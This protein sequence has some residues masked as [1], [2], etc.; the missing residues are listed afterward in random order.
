MIRIKIKQATVYIVLA[1]LQK[2]E[3][4]S[5]SKSWIVEFVISLVV[6]IILVCVILMMIR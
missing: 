6:N 2:R 1:Y 3:T 5:S 4:T